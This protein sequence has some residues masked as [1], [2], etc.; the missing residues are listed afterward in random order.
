MS[1][2]ARVPRFWDKALKGIVYFLWLSG[3]T[4]LVR[5]WRQLW[6]WVLEWDRSEVNLTQGLE[7]SQPHCSL[8]WRRPY[9]Q[10]RKV[11]ADWMPRDFEVLLFFFFCLFVCLF[12]NI[13]SLQEELASTVGLWYFPQS[14]NGIH[15]SFPAWKPLLC[16]VLTNPT[17]YLTFELNITNGQLRCNCIQPWSLDFPSTTAYSTSW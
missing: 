2:S 15:F 11:T 12:F 9:L 17:T 1:R 16:A 14:P 3:V 7:S 13:A 10:A 6:T 8:R 4:V 5:S